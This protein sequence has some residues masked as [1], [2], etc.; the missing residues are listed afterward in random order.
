M[1]FFMIG[2]NTKKINPT[3][4]GIIV[5]IKKKYDIE[6]SSTIGSI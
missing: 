4:P 1:S 5:N 2:F 3:T 6:C